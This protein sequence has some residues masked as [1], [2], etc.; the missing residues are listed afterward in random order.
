MGDGMSA[1]IA[2]APVTLTRRCPL[3][4]EDIEVSGHMA[5]TGDGFNFTSDEAGTTAAWGHQ[6]LHDAVRDISDHLTEFG[7]AVESVAEAMGCTT[8]DVAS[9]LQAL[10]DARCWKRIPRCFNGWGVGLCALHGGHA[11]DC[12]PIPRRG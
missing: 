8:A 12:N 5:P 11:G 6:A 2:G 1:E 10:I 3:C 9:N 7:Q 4:N